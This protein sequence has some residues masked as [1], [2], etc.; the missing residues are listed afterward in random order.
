M[1]LDI[2]RFNLPELISGAVDT[3]SVSDE[4]KGIQVSSQIS[5]IQLEYHGDDVRIQQ[6]YWNILTNAVKFTPPGGFISVS[7][8]LRN[9]AGSGAVGCEGHH[10]AP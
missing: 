8:R 9:R 2:A 10:R 1:K 5:P 6:V 4:A 7:A 3:I